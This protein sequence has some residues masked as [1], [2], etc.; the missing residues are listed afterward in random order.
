MPIRLFVVPFVVLFLLF[1]ACGDKKKSAPVE[2]EAPG[3]ARTQPVPLPAKETLDKLGP[4]NDLDSRWILENP[5]LIVIGHPKKFLN[6]PF[7]RG[8]EQF[9]SE[10]IAGVFLIPLNY[11]KIERFVQ[12][13]APA[14][15]PVEVQE[16]GQRAVRQGL[17]LRRSMTVRF[18]SPVTQDDFLKPFQNPPRVTVETMRRD[19]GG[20]E[21]FDLTG[22]YNANQ[23]KVGVRFADDRTVVLVH[24]F[25]ADFKEVFDGRA[26]R[27]AAV[28]RAG[29]LNLDTCDVAISASR[30]GMNIDSMLLQEMLI[31]FGMTR[32]TAP[33]F[34]NNFRSLTASLRIDAERD[35]PMLDVRFE[36]LTEEGAGEVSEFVDGMIVLAQTSLAAMNERIRQT[37]P[38]SPGFADE[39]LN[40]MAVKKDGGG[41]RF[42]IDK[43]ES[44][45]RTFGDGIKGQQEALLQRRLEQGKHEQLVYLTQA[46]AAYYQ[47]NKKFPSAIRSAD[48]KPLLSWRVALL[49]TVGMEGLYR[50]FKFDQPWD[51]EANKALVEKMPPLF[52]M[53]EGDAESG[54]TMVRFF[55]SEGT[56][57]SNPD[58]KFEDL[59]H[60]RTT[61]LFVS[62]LP[63]Q[64][65]PWTQ[66]D[67]LTLELDKLEETLGSTLLGSTFTGEIVLQPILPTSD[68]RSVQQ[69]K[70][71]EALFKGLP[72]PQTTESVP[73]PTEATP[74][75]AV[76]ETATP[77]ALK[78]PVEDEPADEKPAP[79]TPGPAP[80]ADTVDS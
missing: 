7:G 79:E 42:T 37:M 5:L 64:A 58:L 31:G 66:P 3:V 51:S 26:S 36:T 34:A 35:T 29:R 10:L 14:V 59:K 38:F 75:E 69:R 8:N 55:N 47:A 1:S 16:N 24:G 54:K 49:P 67:D 20:L 6:S 77:P 73:A 50:E 46:V 27:S 32:E 23:Q 2:P 52:R 76:P 12:S 17:V 18:D 22:E 71:F 33:I 53:M 44:F 4:E 15:V 61:M 30:E 65:V 11:A 45:D 78:V 9:L 74:A 62:V 13:V 39:A 72:L 19:L 21:Y 68:P 80:T 48:G 63:A 28:D 70:F 56:P 43:F 60:L 57:M 40:A 25:E 41:I